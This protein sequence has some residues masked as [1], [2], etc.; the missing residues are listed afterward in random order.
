[1]HY[2]NELYHI[3][4]LVYVK[5]VLQVKTMKGHVIQND[6]DMLYPNQVI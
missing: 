1:M 6:N 5:R 2:I 4:S 3:S